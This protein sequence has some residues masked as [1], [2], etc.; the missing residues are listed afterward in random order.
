MPFLRFRIAKRFDGFSLDCEAEFERGVTAV[1]GRSGSGKTT[2]LDAIAGMT[3]PDEGEIVID[4]ETIYS[5]ARRV[6]APL[7]RRRFGY[8]FQHG[9]LF[10][11]MSVRRN[12]RYGYDLTPAGERRH[13]PEELA[14]MLGVSHLLGRSAATLSGGERQRVALARALAISPR[15]LLLDEPLASLDA[16]NRGAILSLLRRVSE[17]LDTPMIFVSHSLSEVMALAPR[18]LALEDG[19]PLAYGATADVMTSANVARFADYATLEN[20]L[21]AEFVSADADEGTSRLKVGDAT[22]IAPRV[23]A[24]PGDAVSVSIRAGDIILS[25]GVPPKTSARN[26]APGVIRETRFA[27]GRALVYVDLGETVVAEVTPASVT[28]LRLER[29]RE[30]YAVIKSNSILAFRAD[31]LV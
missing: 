28:E 3:T 2:L 13:R 11:H 6:D 15:L 12:I 19:K 4:G 17:R 10:P 18:A 14:E 30:V 22:L 7:E 31:V 23:D 8:V 21:E 5:S 26:A 9:A 27:G 1:F 20:I 25:L 29:G 24:A 16:A